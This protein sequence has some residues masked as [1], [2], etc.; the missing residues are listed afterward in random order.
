MMID[1][2]KEKE[3]LINA[4]SDQYSKS[5][6]SLSDYESMADKVN[7]IDSFKELRI[8]QKYVEE[9]CGITLYDDNE[10][11]YVSIFSW[12]NITAKSINGNAGKF[13]SVFGGTQIK[14][15]DLPPGITTLNVDVVFGLIEI[16]VPKNIKLV[17][18]VTPV[19]SGIFVSN[20]GDHNES[21]DRPV[22]H[23]TGKSVFGNVTVIRT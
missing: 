22:L 7:K 15:D 10:H 2:T 12:R 17:N 23:I 3:K 6:I 16:F 18:K 14:I 8:V 4:L 21:D 5:I 9:N 20:I 11:K 19:F 1:V 13:K